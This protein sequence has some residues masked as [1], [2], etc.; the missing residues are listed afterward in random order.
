[1]HHLVSGIKF[2]TFFRQPRPNLSPS[3]SSL[4]LITSAYQFQ[5]HHSLLPSF[6]HS[7]I[8]TN[9]ALRTDFTDYLTVHRLSL[10]NGFTFLSVFRFQ[11]S[12]SFSSSVTFSF[13]LLSTH[14]YPIFGLFL[15]E[16]A[17][18]FFF[19]FSFS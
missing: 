15:S 19:S 17:S 13:L 12:K 18:S 14:I 7:F 16:S 5:H 9:S 10:L 3:D 2:L 1:M 6:L 4:F 8:L 11:F